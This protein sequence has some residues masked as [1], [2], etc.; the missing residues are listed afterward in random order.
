MLPSSLMVFAQAIVLHLND[1][2]VRFKRAHGRHH[3]RHFAHDG[4]VGP[5]QI[6]LP[7]G[8]GARLRERTMPAAYKIRAADL[9]Q[10]LP[11]F[12]IR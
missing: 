2:L 12:E 9:R 4:S 5:F 1:V 3:V 6:I 7:E 11:G 8:R 10:Q